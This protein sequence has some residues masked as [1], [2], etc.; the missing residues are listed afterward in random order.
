M[1]GWYFQYIPIGK[2]PNIKLMST[3][4]QRN[5]LRRFLKHIRK[6]KS[7]FI[8]DFWNDGPFVKGCIA[9]GRGYL[10]INNKGNVEPCVFT[11]F[12]VDNIKEK[13]LKE[14]LNS[15]LFKTIRA[16]QPYHK[17]LLTPCM[18]IDN[19]SVFR[20]IVEETKPYS[21]DQEDAI[22]KDPE[23]IKH[24]DKYSKKMHE[25]TDNVWEKEY[26]KYYKK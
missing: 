25:L 7:I 22:I 11:H 5:E 14:A 10:H 18:I 15:K 4:E 1:F 20:K 9:G 19:P 21:T 23:I 26:A 6:T 24:L 13:S 12:A 16:R 3:P 17:N 8:G 2:K